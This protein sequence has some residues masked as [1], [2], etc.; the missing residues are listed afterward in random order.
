MKRAVTIL[1]LAA[2]A[3]A[4]LET[5]Q[6][7]TTFPPRLESY[8]ASTVKLTPLERQ[9]LFRGE[10]ITRLLDADESKEVAILGAV[11]IN[12]PMRRYIDAVKDIESFEKGAGFKVTR[13][14][15]SPP[16]VE[17]FRGLRIP[18]EDLQDLRRCKV[19]N[20]EVKVGA[21]ALN[22]FH[23]EVNL[24]APNANAA[25]MAW[26]QQLAFEYAVSY[27]KGGDAELAVYRDGSRPTFVAQE[28]R[29]MTAA[30][31]EL[32]TH[33]PNTRRYLLEFPKVSM[34]GFTSFLY[35]QE[36]EFGLKPII[37]IN[38]VVI[39]D[40]PEDAVIA[41][42]LLYASHYFWTGI[43]LRA[44]VP[45]AS[46]GSGFWFVTVSR[47]RSDGLSG[48]TGRIIRGRVRGE[49]EKGIVTA[50]NATKRLMERSH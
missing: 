23:S 21:G 26:L 47:S 20:C 2:L 29:E 36:T 6:G 18:D 40:T 19:G 27:L 39:R 4:P 11:W 28:F 48:F 12:A 15:S 38:H 14:I 10:A 1:A 32:S 17:D 16:K 22:R 37:R 35:W 46:R 5:R 24:N 3:T 9:R 13:K 44:L 34:P 8:L 50:M 41:S 7:G 43:E 25:A 45:D 33:M 42:K 49:V 30:M 31:P